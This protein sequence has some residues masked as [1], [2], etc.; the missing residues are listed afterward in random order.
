MSSLPAHEPVPSVD[1]LLR[2][3]VDHGERVVLRR[4]NDAVAIIPVE[5]LQLLEDLEDAR[6]AADFERALAEDDG[7]RVS[8]DEAKARLGLFD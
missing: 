3:V 2:R 4:G 8:W 7:E 1:T 6:D 5:D